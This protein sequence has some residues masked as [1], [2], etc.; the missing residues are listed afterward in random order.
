MTKVERE[1]LQI[2]HELGRRTGHSANEV[3]NWRL[4]ARHGRMYERHG[5]V[6]GTRPSHMRNNEYAQYLR[7]T[8]KWLESFVHRGLAEA[9]HDRVKAGK[10]LNL[11]IGPL[12]KLTKEGQKLARKVAA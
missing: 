9:I 5:Y 3:T 7:V 12:Y 10:K 11:V 4:W 2:L 8:E 1:T 6:K